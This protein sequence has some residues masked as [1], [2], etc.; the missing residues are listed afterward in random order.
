M[1]PILHPGSLVLIEERARIAA[2]GWR[3][4]HDRPIYFFELRDG[5]ACGWCDLTDGRLI[6]QPHPASQQKPRVFAHPGEVD[7]IGRVAGVAMLLGAGE[8]V[9]LPALSARTASPGR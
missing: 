3:N 9:R 5:Y 6:I 1:Y 2:G 4:E 7:L 8:P